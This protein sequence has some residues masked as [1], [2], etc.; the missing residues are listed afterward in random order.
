MYQ[1]SNN[2]LIST[3]GINQTK[4]R[5]ASTKEML[6]QCTWQEICKSSD[7]IMRAVMEKSSS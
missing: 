1:L 7:T 2:K 6:Y 5:G 4:Q 3:T